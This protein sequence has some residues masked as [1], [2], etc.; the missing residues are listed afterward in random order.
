MQLFFRVDEQSTR[1]F[2][3]FTVLHARYIVHLLGQPDGPQRLGSDEPRQ[4]ACSLGVAP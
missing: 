1:I 2:F 3:Q 4:R